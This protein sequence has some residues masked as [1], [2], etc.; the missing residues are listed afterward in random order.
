MRI[1]LLQLKIRKQ[2]K[3]K[4]CRCLL[5]E[6]LQLIIFR[7]HCRERHVQLLQLAQSL[8]RN[9]FKWLE[10]LSSESL[11]QSHSY[12]S[13]VKRQQ[14]NLIR[15]LLNHV[16]LKCPLVLDQCLPR[17]LSIKTSIRTNIQFIRRISVWVPRSTSLHQKLCK[18]SNK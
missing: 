7:F 1:T 6:S 11:I 12:L 18:G 4:S 3:L 14:L 8:I 17:D 15:F 5:S 13:K 2:S 10:E 9:T 16:I